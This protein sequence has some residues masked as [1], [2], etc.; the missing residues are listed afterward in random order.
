MTTP[1]D[2]DRLTREELIALVRQLIGRITELERSAK[3]PA[4]PFS[5]GPKPGPHKPPGRKAGEGDFERRAAPEVD[6]TGATPTEVGLEGACAHCGGAVEFDDWEDVS[7]TDIPP[8]P[9]P[10]VRRYRVARG[11]CKQCGKRAR[12]Q[13]PD[14]AT[15]QCGATAHRVGP[16][17]MAA[18]HTLHY[19]VGV[20]VRKVPR[21]LKALTGMDV[22]QSAISQHGAKAA[23]EGPVAERHQELREGIQKSPVVYTDDTGWKKAGKTAYLMIFDT[24]DATVFQ[25]RDQHR[26]DEVREV[27]PSTYKGTMVSDRGVSYD[28]RELATVVQQKCNAHIVRNIDEALEGKH[29]KGRWFGVALKG[30]VKEG[31]SM[32]R[33]YHE[34]ERPK[35]RAK[36]A[37]L[38]ERLTW[39][40]R[41]RGLDDDDNQRLLN[42]LGSHHDIG[43][44]IRYLHDPHIEP[45]N[46]RAERGLRP[47]I[48]AR[49]V[50]HCSK[51]DRGARAH[52]AFSSIIASLKKKLAPDRIIDALV[53]LLRGEP[54]PQPI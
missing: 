24:D 36:V 11:H 9:R 25:I 31:I 3:R 50:S 8:T 46:N 49:K 5:K 34:G 1:G 10:E 45:T 23:E 19:E 43:N 39:H 13:H 16:R 30:M 35:Y 44:L 21:V 47:A 42:E 12:G 40:L 18:A 37:D 2:L 20:P 48:I 38:D 28:A 29:G 51:N 33:A 7:T 26:N 15:D 52:E 41:A 14:V 6:E 53:S 27:V 22:T 54:T 17:T 32:W 4:N